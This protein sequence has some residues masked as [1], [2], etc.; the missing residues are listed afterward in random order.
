MTT[1]AQAPGRRSAWAPLR[2]PVFRMLFAAQVV[3]NI[4][5]WMQTVGAQWFLVE[6]SGS[7]AFV[8]WIQTASQLPVLLLSLV[9]GVTADLVDRRRLLLVTSLASCVV[10]GVL[11]AVT[12]TGTLTPWGL[13][14]LTFLLGCSAAMTGPAWQAIQPQIVP[15][16]ELPEASALGSIA[17]NAARAVGPA[18]AGVIVSAT[19]PGAVFALNTLS[20]LAVTAA[21][22]AWR[23]DALPVRTVR[24]RAWPGLLAGLRYV[25]SAPSVRRI[26][27][28]CALFALPGSALWALLPSAARDLMGADAAG[29]SLLLALLGAGAIAGAVAMPRLRAGLSRSW[30]LAGGA[31]LFAVGTAAA[32]WLPLPTAAAG[33][34]V[35]GVGWL[36]CLTTLNATMQLALAGWVRARGLATYML[37]FMGSQALG[38]FLW[39]ALAD[40]VGVRPTL[41]AA[42][43]ALVLVAA[44]V[45]VL[46]LLAHSGT[47][48][49]S[50][51]PLSSSMPTLELDAPP[52]TPT[53]IV[54]AYRVRP[55]N[56][57]AFVEAMH[58]VR[59]AR[60]RSGGTSWQLLRRA[61]DPGEVLETYVAPSWEEHQLQHTVRWTGYDAQVLA[62]AVALAEGEPSVAHYLVQGVR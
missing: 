20:F 5:T 26:L 49:R 32:G 8:A 47:I 14:G 43:A 60:E 18:V 61:E 55:E 56:M 1:T 57:A 10:A 42:A 45:P 28:R 31:L 39:G 36:A 35:A 22:L 52:A 13:L 11:T 7:P 15:R 62:R 58:P 6:A 34:L 38:S 9:A 24:E 12:L 25:R 4:G 33:A 51:V 48:D 2:R 54:V 17:V 46:P 40:A 37:V 30:L 29:Y 50:V 16:D 3:S 19:G 27:V 44:T 53:A 59:L 41:T 23:E 21:L